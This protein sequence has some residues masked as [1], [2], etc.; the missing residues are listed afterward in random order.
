M[1]DALAPG[2]L[3]AVPQ[4]LDPNFQQTV[5][6]L[7]QQ[8]ENGALGIVV[9]RDTSLLLKD[10]CKDHEIGYSGDPKKRVRLGGPVQ[11]E[12][13]LVVYGPEHED[14]EGRPVVEGLHVS[15]S[16]GTLGRLCTLSKGRFHCFSG[17]AGWAP[18]Q[19]EREINEGSWII[20]P[21]SADLV[22]DHPPDG[23]WSKALAD[24]GLDPAAI[25]PGSED[26]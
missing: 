10:L 17:Y 20:A 25:V 3:I 8:G 7:L 4:M 6:L 12:Q 16:T 13:G 22:L 9:N 23:M 21:V 1:I 19:L 11:P 18:G 2:F 5:V 24:N 15:A 26:A 14:P